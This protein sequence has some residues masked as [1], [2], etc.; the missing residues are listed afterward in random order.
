MC[1][2]GSGCCKHPTSVG[3]NLMGLVDVDC[4]STYVEVQRKSCLYFFDRCYITVNMIK[5][6]EIISSGDCR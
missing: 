2:H 3:G 6:M 1:T 4:S 5:L